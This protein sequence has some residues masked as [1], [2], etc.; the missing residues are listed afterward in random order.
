MSLK[1]RQKQAA[2]GISANLSGLVRNGRD[3]TG[4]GP[5]KG[6]HPLKGISVKQAAQGI[7]VKPVRSDP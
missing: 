4:L 2:Q 1:G 6:R 5:L 3:L 7:S